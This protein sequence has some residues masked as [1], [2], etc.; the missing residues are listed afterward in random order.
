MIKN[1]NKEDILTLYQIGLNSPELE[2]EPGQPFI[3][4]EEFEHMTKNMFW[5]KYVNNKPIG[6]IY[7]VLFE[8]QGC[9]VYLVI[10][11]KY[12]GQGFGRKLVEKALEELKNIGVSKIYAW[13]RQGSAANGLIDKFRFNRGGT[14]TYVYL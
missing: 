13:V 11:K 14:F 9:V 7:V 8:N 3:S 10:S 1:P 5:A 6:F 2:S 4:F 12:R